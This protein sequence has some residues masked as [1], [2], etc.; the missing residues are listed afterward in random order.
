ME[1]MWVEIAREGM[2][3]HMLRIKRRRG[4]RVIGRMVIV[5]VVWMVWQKRCVDLARV[6]VFLWRYRSIAFQG[7]QLTSK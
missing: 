1:R 4:E 7:W 2:A 3:I 6:W 5:G